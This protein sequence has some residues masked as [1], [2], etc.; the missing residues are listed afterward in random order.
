MP[1]TIAASSST[2]F[3]WNGNPLP[4]V[5]RVVPDGAL[6]AR[7]DNVDTG[8][9]L[10]V[11]LGSTVGGSVPA[12]R[13]ALV[14]AL[15]GIVS[16]A[17]GGGGGGGGATASEINNALKGSAQP[18]TQIAATA[19]DRSGTIG[20]PG[21]TATIAANAARLSGYVQN[22]NPTGILKVKE[23]GTA[24]ATLGFRLEPGETYQIRS[25]GSVSIWSELGGAYE[26]VEYT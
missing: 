3:L 15:A 21:G 24:S 1:V 6:D 25:R 16:P 19:T 8:Q 2:H 14:T 22:P 12:D 13:N 7:L 5:Y 11:P 4:R 26:A 20:S 10:N 9:W 18:S 17:V 23:G